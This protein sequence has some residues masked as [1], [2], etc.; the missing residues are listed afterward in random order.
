MQHEDE[1]MTDEDKDKIFVMPIIL[2]G[3]HRLRVIA[4]YMESGDPF[5][6]LFDNEVITSFPGVSPVTIKHCAGLQSDRDDALRFRWLL[7]GNGYF[8]EENY[9]CGRDSSEA[10][11]DEARRCI[12]EAMRESQI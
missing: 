2:N 4:G 3:E 7:N 12:D 5:P 10:D 8:M 6:D 9:L 1:E 11:E